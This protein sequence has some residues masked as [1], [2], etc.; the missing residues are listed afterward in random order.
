[1]YWTDG[2][3]LV[4]FDGTNW[5]IYNTSNSGLPS[6]HVQSISIEENGAKWIGLQ[7]YGVA[8]FDGANRISYKT[9]NSGLPSDAI[10][11]II[12]DLNKDKDFGKLLR[13]GIKW[14]WKPVFY[15]NSSQKQHSQ[16]ASNAT[17]AGTQEPAKK[18][19]PALLS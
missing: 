18:N 2:N 14:D 13:S 11:S 7:Y 9:T 16:S 4:K 5:T 15:S 8:K 1:M 3:G 19:L 6:N 12:I 10:N 17:F